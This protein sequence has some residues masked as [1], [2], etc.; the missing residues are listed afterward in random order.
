MKLVSRQDIH[1]P[2]KCKK[3]TF[4]LISWLA[5]LSGEGEG[6]LC[7]LSGR[8]ADNQMLL[9]GPPSLHTG[10]VAHCR[11]RWQ[12]GVGS[13]A[14]EQAAPGR[15]LHGRSWSC[16]AL[17][18]PAPAQPCPCLSYST[19]IPPTCTAVPGLSLANLYNCKPQLRC[20]FQ[21]PFT[22]ET[23]GNEIT[24]QQQRQHS[25]WTKKGPQF[26]EQV[27]SFCLSHF[28][29]MIKENILNNSFGN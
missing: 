11:R 25:S 27:F 29:R 18:T 8:S 15:A 12:W 24:T 5:V 1:W 20:P 7:C 13:G 28:S 10:P 23:G 22:Q 21:Q 6:H 9:P 3:H 14:P 2:R 26:R 17:S 4:T 16:V 19:S